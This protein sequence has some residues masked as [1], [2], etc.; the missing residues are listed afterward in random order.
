MV[1]YFTN[2]NTVLIGEPLYATGEHEISPIIKIIDFGSSEMLESDPPEAAKNNILAIGDVGSLP[3][4]ALVFS[5]RLTIRADYERVNSA[6]RGR[7]CQ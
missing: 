3:P 6:G 2:T 5:R 1:K 4:K 7:S